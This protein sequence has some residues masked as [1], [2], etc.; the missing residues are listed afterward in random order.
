MR[1]MIQQAKRRILVADHSKFGRVAFAHIA[2]LDDFDT[3]ITDDYEDNR[4]YYEKISAMGVNVI[5]V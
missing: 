3:L 1:K 5:T 4:E 2:N